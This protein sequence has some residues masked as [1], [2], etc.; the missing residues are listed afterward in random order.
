MQ[1]DDVADKR[2]LVL[3]PSLVINAFGRGLWGNK[4]ASM[5]VFKAPNFP[6]CVWMAPYM[7]PYIWLRPPLDLYD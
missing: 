2:K 7:V 1:I 6:K 5:Q 3:P 4:L